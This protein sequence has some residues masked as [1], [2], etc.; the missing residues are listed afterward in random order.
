MNDIKD[1]LKKSLNRPYPND[2]SYA[3]CG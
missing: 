1:I 2:V 3:P